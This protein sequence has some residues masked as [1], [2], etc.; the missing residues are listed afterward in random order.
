MERGL[1]NGSWAVQQLAGLLAGISSY[2]D[3]SSMLTGAAHRIAEAVDAEVCAIVA[4]D[5]PVPVAI[6]FPADDVPRD[7][8]RRIVAADGGELAVAGLGA[9]PTAVV[10]LGDEHARHVVLARSSSSLTATDLHLVRSMG[11][12]L[13]LALQLR[14]TADREREL[15]ERSEAQAAALRRA[16][17]ALLEASRTKDMVISVA[18]HELRTPLTAILGFASTLRERADALD[19]ESH[20]AYLD[21]IASQGNRLLRL[22][23]DLLTVGRIEAGRTHPRREPVPVVPALRVLTT[24]HSTEVEVRGPVDAAATVDPGHLDQIMLNLLANAQK[25][26]A[27]PVW[28]EVETDGEEITVTV[29]DAGD[30]VPE[31]FVPNLFDRFTQA[32]SGEAR[33]SSGAGLG[34][35]IVR[36]LVEANGGTV[37]YERSAGRSRF[38]VRLPA[39]PADA[40][41]ADA[42]QDMASPPLA[43]P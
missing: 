20:A 37:H 26:G 34:L 32:S 5:G 19:A 12:V 35:A 21:I 2:D 8:L 17:A 23:D 36:G 39:A 16:N 13:T 33:V 1:D 42:R 38:V 43:Q 30:G 24:T 29:V 40:V 31:A 6:G 11:Q 9:V 4:A 27:P 25:Y 10:D 28:T 14:R 22:I 7:A 3:E 15:R 41:A 18:S